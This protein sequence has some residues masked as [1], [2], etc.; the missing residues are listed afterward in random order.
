MKQEMTSFKKIM[1]NN[2]VQQQNCITEESATEILLYG[3]YSAAIT[4]SIAL[5]SIPITYWNLFIIPLSSF[6][7]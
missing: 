3:N 6:C 1:L 4:G 7:P 5:C 2:L